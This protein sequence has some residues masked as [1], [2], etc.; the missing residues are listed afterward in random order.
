MRT[1]IMVVQAQEQVSHTTRFL[2]TV[3]YIT[4][5]WPIALRANLYCDDRL[6]LHY[7]RHLALFHLGN[8]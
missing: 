5:Y 3:L 1:F 7:I 4:E 2:V 8:N 6:G